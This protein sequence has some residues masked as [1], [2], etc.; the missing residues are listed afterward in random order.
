LSMALAFGV[1]A[2]CCLVQLLELI[3]KRFRSPED[4]QRLLGLPIVAHIPQIPAARAGSTPS[5]GKLDGAVISPTLYTFHE[6]RGAAA[7]A[8]R[9]VRNS[10]YFA[11]NGESRRTIQ[12]TSPHP[13]DGKS[14]LAANL[15][16]SV[17]DSGKSVL[18]VDA[19]MRRPTIHKYFAVDRDF[20]LSRVL[21]EEIELPEAIHETKI[22]NLHVMP[23]GPTP[24]NP[25]DLLVLPRFQELLAAVRQ[26]FDFVVIDTPPLLTVTDAAMVSIR[27]DAVVLVLCLQRDNRQSVTRASEMLNLANAKVA[28]IVVNGVGSPAT[29]G[30]SHYSDGSYDQAR[31]Y[32][33]HG[34]DDEPSA[35]NGSRATV[36]RSAG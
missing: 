22:K 19:D 17:A 11:K 13:G 25:A 10:L 4:L 30:Y 20:G 35:S 36:G 27:V 12:I 2:G 21:A 34:R 14:S 15:A 8:C 24:P 31:R 5:N 28:G 6:A 18:L 7:E 32:V 29:Y 1:I 23:C 3:D 16:V 9:A 33:D 26:Q